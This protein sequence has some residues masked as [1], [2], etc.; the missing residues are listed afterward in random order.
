[1]AA[2]TGT[3]SAAPTPDSNTERPP[4]DGRPYGAGLR[5]SDAGFQYR[6]VSARCPPSWVNRYPPRALLRL[7]RGSHS[8]A[9]AG[10]PY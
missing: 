5:D 1:M 10:P 8:A 6:T 7:L 2:P 9:R 4:R 3:A